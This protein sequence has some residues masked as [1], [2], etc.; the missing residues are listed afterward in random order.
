MS[1]KI[2]GSLNEFYNRWCKRGHVECDAL[3]D[4]K[5]NIIIVIDRRIS[6]NSQNTNMLPRKTK[7]SCRYLKSGIEELYR[8]FVL[9]PADKAAN[10]VVVV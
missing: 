1:Q 6:F 9:V 10:N 3:K 2:V 8:K 5:L 7:I 4:W